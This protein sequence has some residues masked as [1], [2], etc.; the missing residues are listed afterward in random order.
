M[1]YENPVKGTRDRQKAVS[2]APRPDRDPKYPAG[3]VPRFSLD[4][5]DVQ[6]HAG[7]QAMRRLF[8]EGGP[9]PHL[10]MWVPGA[11]APK[12][13]QTVLDSPGRALPE[14]AH[15][16]A[17]S[18]HVDPAVVRIHTDP[19]A[20]DVAMMLEARAFAVGHHI[21]FGPDQF[22]AGSAD[23]RTLIVHELSHLAQAG[24]GREG[25]GSAPG[26][27]APLMHES[28]AREGDPM[29]TERV[30]SQVV[31]RHP[32][33]KVLKWAAKWLSR[34]SVKLI[35]KHIA[36]HTREI[37]GK[38]IHSVFSNP[39]QVKY[40]IT[41][42]VDEASRVVERQAATAATHVIEEGTIR[43]VRQSTRSPG[44]VRW[45]I[46]K[47][48]AKA[49]GTEGQRILRIVV[50]QTGRVVTA[51]PT[52]RLL[53]LGV[54]AAGLEL[55]S[56]R[57]AEAAERVQGSMDRQAA[58]E[59]AAQEDHSSWWEWVPIIGDIWGGDLNAGE[60]AELAAGREG[61]QRR[62][63]INDVVAQIVR[64]IE[65]DKQASLGP[66]ERA[67]VEEFVRMILTSGADL[68]EDATDVTT[69]EDTLSG[70]P[71]AEVPAVPR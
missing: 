71:R 49:V 47:T 59:A 62:R 54:T 8:E 5:S 27:S 64:D 2:R 60:S 32:A 70:P 24:G 20:A 14:E 13:V 6:R 1:K 17:S 57:S 37:I 40:M 42:A 22:A 10:R 25:I 67:D 48:F 36:K 31:Q 21:V 29:G 7:N 61:E 4:F 58:L 23:G 63:Y 33:E 50:D 39:R 45:V 44:K 11:P 65:Q 30:T 18:L 53:A 26:G 9:W 41:R 12:S 35:T 43:V 15:G 34:R 68:L 69:T 51:F 3:T 38:S 46:E 55:F 19:E 28:A 66:A 56:E 52:D 16:L